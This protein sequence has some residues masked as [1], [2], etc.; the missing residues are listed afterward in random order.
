[1]GHFGII[2]YWLLFSS[3]VIFSCFVLFCFVSCLAISECKLEIVVNVLLRTVY[4]AIFFWRVL[5]HI[6]IVNSITGWSLW[7]CVGL[8]LCF[9][10]SDRLKFEDFF[11]C[12]SNLTELS[13]QTWDLSWVLFLGFVRVDLWK[14]SSSHCSHSWSTAFLMSQLNIRI[15]NK[16]LKRPL[17]HVWVGTSISYSNAPLLCLCLVS[18]QPRRSHSLV[19]LW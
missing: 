17:H 3:W 8:F 1:M 16:M 13:L 2:S 4:S 15:I 11:S 10:R 9:V 14:T 12:L 18:S 19:G 6:L 7:T 5:I